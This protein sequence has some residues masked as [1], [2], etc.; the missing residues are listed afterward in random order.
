MISAKRWIGW[1]FAGWAAGFVLAI[2]FIVA[3]EGLG[4]RETQFPLALGMGLGVGLLQARVTADLFGERRRWVLASAVGLAAPFLVADLMRL[5]GRPVPYSLSVYVGLGGATA[6]LAQWR[7]LRRHLQRAGWW[8]LA[9][10]IGWLAGG[11]TVWVNEHVMPRTPGLIGAL[12]YIGVVLLGGLVLGVIGAA[13]LR[14]IS[15]HG[16][17]AAVPSTAAAVRGVAR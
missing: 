7:V 5:F 17:G 12:Q 8:L 6:G 9:A 1:T 11:S 4:L 3:A 16:I 10:P 2:L 15:G 13:A 14:F